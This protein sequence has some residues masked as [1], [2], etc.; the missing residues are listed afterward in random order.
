[1]RL[2]S[3]SLRDFRCFERLDLQLHPR[4]TVLI[5]DNGAGKTAILDA[6]AIGLS[7]VLRHLSSANQ[8][9]KGVGIK[10]SDFRLVG[11]EVRGGRERWTASDTA[12]VIMETAGNLTWD[13]WRPSLA[14]KE[15]EHKVGE[16]ALIEHLARIS[17]SLKTDEPELLP[18]FAY[19][20]AR[21]G[22]IEIPERLRSTQENYGHPTS[23]LVGA[24]E[25]LSD[26]KEMLKWF[27]GEEA[28]ELRANKGRAVP[29]YTPSKALDAVRASLRGLLGG[30][31]HNP[32]FNRDHKLV[33]EAED[34]GAL[35][36][37]S[38]LSQGY[39]SMLALG[40]DFARRLALANPGLDFLRPDTM[41]KVWDAW[42]DLDL[43]PESFSEAAPL[44]AP[45][46]MLVDEI[47]LHLHPSWQQRVLGDLLRTFPAT[48]FIVT[49][50][51]P[52]VLTS[53]DA[54]CIRRIGTVT[55]PDTGRSR[56]GVQGVSWQTRGVIS[57]DVLARIMGVDPVPAVPE[58]QQLAQYHALI[59]QNLHE[60]DEGLHL[61]EQLQA[62]FGA[63]HPVMLN[64]DRMI[65]LQGYKQKLPPLK[66]RS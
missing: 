5:G 31:Y 63:D 29:E 15:P 13:V 54:A 50:H 47:D 12:Q 66:Q 53:V 45:A 38:Q 16:A 48:Q 57:S 49:T 37:V 25:P 41:E 39:Q 26:F 1:M 11:L 27:D 19:Y 17:D 62:H 34:S 35:F 23:A 18:V 55:D 46:I 61:R 14:G 60:S 7:P 32:H 51:S 6:I 22:Y 56:V 58:A 9:L 10:D 42:Q 24:L 8:R 28:A 2:K 3:I 52:Q 4:L 59:E 64:C 43:Q 36:Q 21:R 30:T 44:M 33:V 40:L 20:G 65:R